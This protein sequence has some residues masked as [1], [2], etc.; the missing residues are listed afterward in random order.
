MAEVEKIRQPSLIACGKED[1]LTPIKYSQF[2]NQKLQGS[3]MEL[4][5]GAGHLVMIENPGALTQAIFNFLGGL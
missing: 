5:D 2:L 1:R 3:R 4:I